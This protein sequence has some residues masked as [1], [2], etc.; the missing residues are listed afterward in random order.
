[1]VPRLLLEGNSVSSVEGATEEVVVKSTA[2]KVCVFH[3]RR[4][5]H[6]FRVSIQVLPCCSINCVGFRT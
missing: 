4:L 6:Q 1:M 5:R 3:G 2:V